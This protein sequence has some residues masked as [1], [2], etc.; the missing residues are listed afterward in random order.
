MKW[1]S[2]LVLLFSF[3][4]FSQ[5]LK[6]TG[7]IALDGPLGKRFDYL[8]VD[9]KHQRLFM[10][11]LGAD[12]VYVI[13]L[14]TEKLIKTIYDTPGVEG[15]EYVEDLQKIYTSNWRDHSIGVVDLQTMKVVKKLP[16]KDK[17]DGS[18]YAKDFHKLYV[19][20]EKAKTLIVVDV[21]TDK[22]IKTIHFQSETGMPQYDPIKKRIYVNLQD[23]NLFAVVNPETD[24]VED[25]FPVGKCRGNH[26]MA[27]DPTHRLAFLGC[28]KTDTVSIFH[29]DHHKSIADFIVPSGV[30]VVAYD[31]VLQRVYAACDSGAISILQVND[32]THS[33]KLEDFKVEPKVHSLAVNIENHK[34]YVP[35]QEEKGLTAANLLI[36]EAIH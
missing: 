3:T 36:Y 15:I 14:K 34:L 20:D 1:L 31:P 9:Y 29:L 30:D 6:Q 33:H 8:K 11:H 25:K 23:Q 24:A 21:N 16:A 17:P 32:A 22:V 26:G 18:A 10:A 27:L 7:S 28:E 4:A 5:N 13:D 2:V 12:R 35:E 19:S